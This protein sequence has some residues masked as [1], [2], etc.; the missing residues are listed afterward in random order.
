[1]GSVTGLRDLRFP[2][3]KP[4]GLA[5]LRLVLRNL[6]SR[7]QEREVT[8]ALHSTQVDHLQDSCS[9]SKWFERPREPS[10]DRCSPSGWLHG[11]WQTVLFEWTTGWG[12]HPFRAVGIMIVLV[13]CLTPIDVCCTW[14]RGPGCSG[15]CGIFRV[16]P[17]ERLDAEG[18]G[19]RVVEDFRVE[20]ISVR[21]RYAMV[22]GLYFAL[23]S[24]FHIGWRDINVG[25]WN[26]KTTIS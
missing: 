18:E 23:L 17:R 12:L 16:W 2:K 1:M 25:G 6:G 21:F 20:R 7:H 13:C 19:F 9:P 24:T 8:F 4:G 5:E 26:H 22:W 11:A 10:G 3:D 15:S 14:V